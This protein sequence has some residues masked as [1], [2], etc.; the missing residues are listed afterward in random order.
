MLT[1]VYMVISDKKLLKFGVTKFKTQAALAVA[2]GVT[3][4]LISNYKRGVPMS[5]DNRNKLT[6]MMSNEN[7]QDAKSN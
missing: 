6:E 2:L 5:V 7:K 1:G 4:Q 3:R